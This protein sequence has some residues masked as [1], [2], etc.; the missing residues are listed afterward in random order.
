LPYRME[1]SIAKAWASE[2]YRQATWLATGIQGGVAY[3]EDHDMPLYY[4]W[5]KAAEVNLGDADFHREMIAREL[6]D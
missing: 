4:R 6:L 2:Y 1:A 5:A 3:M